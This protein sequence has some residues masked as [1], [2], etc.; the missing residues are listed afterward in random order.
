MIRSVYLYCGT[1]FSDNGERPRAAQGSVDGPQQLRRGNKAS[2]KT[3]R[4]V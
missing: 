1:L 3:F 4:T 2:C